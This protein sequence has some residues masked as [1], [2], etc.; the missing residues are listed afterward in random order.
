MDGEVEIEMELESRRWR[1]EGGGL[2]LRAI[3]KVKVCWLWDEQRE[4]QVLKVVTL[5]NVV[6]Y[7]QEVH[8]LG[9]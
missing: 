5:V 7:I 8:Q 2:G 6:K 4:K 1:P 3:V 9:R